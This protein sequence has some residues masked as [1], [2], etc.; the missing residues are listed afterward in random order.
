MTPKAEL[1][2]GAAKTGAVIGSTGNRISSE[3]KIAVPLESWL[4]IT[5]RIGASR[6]SLG[7]AMISGFNSEVDLRLEFVNEQ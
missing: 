1:S 4:V 2:F 6:L 3:A 5:L 7:E